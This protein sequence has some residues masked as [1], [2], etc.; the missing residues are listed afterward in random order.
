MLDPV[1]IRIIEKPLELIAGVF[2]LLKIPKDMV[3]IIGFIIG[4]IAAVFIYFH[5]YKTALL[6]ILINRL[7]DGIDGALAKL[8][9]PTDAG[10]FLD[11]TLDFIFYSSIVFAFALSDPGRNGI[12]ACFLILSFMG[13][14]SS[15][16][17]FSVMAEKN[18]IKSVE[19]P[20][21]SLYYLGGLMEG[22]ETILFFILFCSLPDL[23]LY[24]ATV[25]AILCWITTGIRIYSGYK[26][27]KGL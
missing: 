26:T 3:T 16:L 11:I 20:N 14:G 17:A 7:F 27:L 21:K 15:F 18:K 13:T 4:I 12:A 23:F 8:T 19:Y 25:F 2:R 9:K 22:T 5:L 10:G 1:A 24:L 6:F